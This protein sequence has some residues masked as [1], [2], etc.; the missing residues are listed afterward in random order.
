MKKIYS[1]KG[2][3]LRSMAAL[4]VLV[5][6]LHLG[7]L[8][9]FT[10]AAALRDREREVGMERTEIITSAS[11]YSPNRQG[12][13]R[14]VLSGAGEELMVSE[15]HF[16]P[17]TGWRCS[18]SWQ[19]GRDGTS[20]QLDGNASGTSEGTAAFLCG[21]AADRAVTALEL[22]LQCRRWYGTGEDIFVPVTVTEFVEFGGQ[23]VFFLVT[24]AIPATYTLRN[25]WLVT[26]QEEKLLRSW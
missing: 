1:R 24:D 5:L 9:N 2:K 21:W 6:A 12:R 17:L 10:P 11:L 4:A 15:L 23:R 20:I 18:S 26:G 8:W 13:V 16:N 3:A 7:D 22:R 19:M 14:M 25:V